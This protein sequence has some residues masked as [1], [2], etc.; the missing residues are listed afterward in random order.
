RRA[1]PARGR[2]AGLRCARSQTAVDH[3]REVRWRSGR[4]REPGGGRG[5][6]A[7]HAGGRHRT[8]PDPAGVPV[9]HGARPHGDARGLPALRSQGARAHAHQP[10]AVRGRAVSEFS[11]R[12]RVYWEDTDGGGVVYYAN[13]LKFM[14]RA[15]P[16]W[17]RSLGHSQ[18]ELAEKYGFVF[19][20]VEVQVNYRKPAHLD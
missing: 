7:R 8:L 19:A 9:A 20:V 14:E 11:W 3:H 13:Y 18:A 2:S 16:E 15:R 17:L 4:H 1:R 6:G 12:T 5:R 10:A